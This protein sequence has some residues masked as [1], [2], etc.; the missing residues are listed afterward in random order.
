MAERKWRTTAYALVVRTILGPGCCLALGERLISQAKHLPADQV[1]ISD[2]QGRT[3]HALGVFGRN[4]L[5]LWVDKGALRIGTMLAGLFLLRYLGPAD[6]GLYSVALAAGVFANAVLDLGLTRYASRA[7]AADAREGRPILA[8]SL[9]VTL[10]SAAAEALL[11]VIFARQQQ[12]YAACLC[13]GLIVSNV[14]GTNLLC[15]FMLTADLRS[16]AVLPGSL[17]N[18][19]GLIALTFLV[20]HWR[21][22]VFHL[23]L[24]L[25]LRAFVVLAARIAPLRVFFPTGKEWCVQ[26]FWRILAAASPYFSYSL[27]EFGYSRIPLLCLTLVAS[28]AEVG[29]FAAATTLIAIFPQLAFA[30]TDALLPVMTRLHE[31]GHRAETQLLRQQLLDV[32][33]LLTVPLSVF[34]SISAPEICAL[35]GPHFGPAVPVLRI[36]G[37]D[38]LLLVLEGLGG[39]FLVAGGSISQ[40]RNMLAYASVALITLNLLLGSFWGA[41]GAAA[42]SVLAHA[43]LL[44]GY[45]YALLKAGEK[46]QAGRALWASAIAS[47]AML[48]VALVPVSPWPIFC[49]APLALAVY[50]G[51]LLLIAPREFRQACGTLRVCFAPAPTLS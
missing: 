51:V 44:W 37:F 31:Y 42:A 40:R 24:G 50:L 10:L 29:C 45:L 3:G 26:E 34:L 19:S 22:S 23:L 30:A 28:R 1:D 43:L 33:W 48:V 47:L 49:A 36:G 35:L 18:A 13:T 7:V 46:L 12:W 4:A 8:L 2:S 21:L 5:W 9:L 39:A 14:E 27:A 16:R 38:G 17:L 6:F 11:V 32:F 20:I 41:R 25:T 15:S